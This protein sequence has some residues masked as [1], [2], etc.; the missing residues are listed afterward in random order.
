MKSRP[1]PGQEPGA[2]RW[3]GLTV[4]EGSAPGGSQGKAGV[5]WVRA[6]V[7][8]REPEISPKRPRCLLEVRRTIT[9]RCGPGLAAGGL[10]GRLAGTRVWVGAARG[11]RAELL[12]GLRGC[13][14]A[15]GVTSCFPHFL[16]QTPNPRPPPCP[17]VRKRGLSTPGVGEPAIPASGN[18]GEGPRHPTSCCRSSPSH[19]SPGHDSSQPVLRPKVP[20]A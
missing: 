1:E 17:P 5:S 18:G 11:A 3:A 15:L 7:S 2:P 12:A 9:P 10:W 14:R 4:S 20:P 6:G 16:L 19:W 13:S 8:A